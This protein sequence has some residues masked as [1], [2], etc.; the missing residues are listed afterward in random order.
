M[1]FAVRN[2]AGNYTVYAAS[3]VSG[4]VLTPVIVHAVGHAG[5]ARGP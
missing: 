5:T 4:L 1:R 2:L 3:I